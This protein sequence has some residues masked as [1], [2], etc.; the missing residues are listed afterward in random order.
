MFQLL[1]KVHFPAL[2]P[3]FISISASSFSCFPLSH[4]IVAYTF[5]FI[6]NSPLHTPLAQF[7]ICTFSYKT[8]SVVLLRAALP[9]PPASTR[10]NPAILKVAAIKE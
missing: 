4:S 9:G 8:C 2:I 6:H 5:I 1:C 10:C 3:P 7:C